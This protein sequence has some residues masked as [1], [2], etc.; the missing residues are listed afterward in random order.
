MSAMARGLP[1]APGQPGTMPATQA[2]SVRQ[3]AAFAQRTAEVAVAP[4]SLADRAVL[5]VGG[6]SV[7]VPLYRLVV[8]GTGLGMRAA[9]NEGA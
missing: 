8:E 5:C 7:S 6:R 4:G 1:A 9:A 3:A 2:R